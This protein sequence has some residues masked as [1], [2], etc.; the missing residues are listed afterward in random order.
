MSIFQRAPKIEGKVAVITGA[1][2]GIGRALAINLAQRGVHLALCD[3]D[4]E[5]LT[6]THHLLNDFDVQVSTRQLNVTDER[7]MSKWAIDVVQEHGAVHMLFNNAGVALAGTVSGTSLEQYRWILEINFFGVVNG[8]K[9][10][11]PLMENNDWAHIVNI[12]SLFGLAGFPLQSGYCASKSAVKGFTE[13]LRVDLEM[14]GSKVSC[15]SVHP[16]G[17]KTN[18][19]KRSV[20]T[21]S[22]IETTGMTADQSRM[23][24]DKLFIT[25]ADK[26]AVIILRGM[27]ANKRRILV[28][29]DVSL[30]DPVLRLFP[31]LFQWFVARTHKL[32]IERVAKKHQAKESAL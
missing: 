14:A 24:F 19:A 21:S 17:I 31:N 8:T 18:I 20:V 2:S 1:G 27:L 30:M 16:G 26:A 25:S 13:S 6:E 3:I 29:A 22:V 32:Y 23:E 11:L 12:S 7:A 5:G 9:A 15:S 28:G 4:Q 10:F